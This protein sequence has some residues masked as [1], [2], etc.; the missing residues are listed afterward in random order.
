M[1]FHRWTLF[2]TGKKKKRIF[3]GYGYPQGITHCPGLCPD[4]PLQ[5]KTFFLYK[6]SLSKLWFGGKKNLYKKFMATTI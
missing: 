1:G 4:I 3:P 6:M 5:S 2:S